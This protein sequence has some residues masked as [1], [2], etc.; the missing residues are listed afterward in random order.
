MYNLILADLFKLR[1]SMAIKILIGITTVSAVVMAVFAYLVPQGKIDASSAGIGFLFSDASM[2]SLI[3]AVIAGIFI[4]GDFDN[5]IIHDAAAGGCSRLAII[6]SKTAVFFCALTFVLIP[7]AVITAIGISSGSKFSLGSMAAGF[8]HVLTSNAGNSISASGIWKIIGLMLV[9]VIL[10][11]A[12]MSICVP[13][14]F[15][16][17]KPVLIVPINYG[18]SILYPQLMKI[19]ER[20]KAL[21][22]IFALTP[23]GGNYE[24][25]T[26]NTKTGCIIKAT[27]VSIIFIIVMTAVTY[28][29]FR[30]SEIR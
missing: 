11:W 21:D 1:K 5:K 12:Q 28:L 9:L 22:R 16:L 30:K 8:L 6:L 27:F 15:A 26:L 20:N 13:L 10:Y 4:C 19:A 3:G 17:K 14:A 25:M 23:F 18:F 29:V 24:L 2:I 7:Y